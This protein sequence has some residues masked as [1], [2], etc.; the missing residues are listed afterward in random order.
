MKLYWSIGSQPGRAV[1]TL[2]DIGKISCELIRMNV[3]K[4]ELRTES[5]LKLYPQGTIPLLV[6]GDFIVG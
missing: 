5:Y 1:K 3:L 4:K 6:D 2:L